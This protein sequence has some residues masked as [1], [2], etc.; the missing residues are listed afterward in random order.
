MISDVA[1]LRKFHHDVRKLQAE[2]LKHG[3]QQIL[4]EALT[5]ANPQASAPQASKILQLSKHVCIAAATLAIM[6]D[7]A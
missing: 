3:G 5:H 1:P 2:T 4:D 6:F 7:E